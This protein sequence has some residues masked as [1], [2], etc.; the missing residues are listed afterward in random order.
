MNKRLVSIITAL[1]IV[2]TFNVSVLAEPLSEKIKIQQQKIQENTK[3]LKDAQKKREDLEVTVEKMDNQI[4]G[5]MKNINDTKKNI[6]KT[7]NDI[8]VVEKDIEKAENNIKT[9][10][11]LFN[12]RVRAMYVSGAGSYLDIILEAKGLSDLIS[13]VEAVKKVIEF[14]N[15]IIAD[16]NGKKQ[17]IEKKKEILNNQNNKLLALKADNEKKLAEMNNKRKEQYNLVAELER[18]EKMYASKINES[19]SYINSAMAQ[20]NSIRKSAPK[21]TPSRGSASISSNSIVAYASNFLGTP[22][23]WGGNGPSTFDCSGYV[24]YVYEHFGVS[25]PRVAEDQQ[26]VGSSVSRDELQPGDL[27]FFGYP[28]HHV[29]IYVGDNCYMHAPKTGD[30]IKISPLTRSDYSGARRVR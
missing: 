8:K 18:Q 23:E 1:T 10:Q 7:Q 24:K 15:K 12:K 17:D 25:L 29:G 14:D 20:I 26:N 13:K 6:K 2:A 3:S 27:V 5:L 19:Q 4:E 22:Y 16:L 30:V 28:A 11:D 21:Y 9:E